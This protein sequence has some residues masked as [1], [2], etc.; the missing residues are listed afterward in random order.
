MKY[1]ADT[2]EIKDSRSKF[3]DPETLL[4]KRAI[5]SASNGVI[6]TDPNRTDNPIVFC[7]A[8]FERIT[9]YTAGE[10]LGRNCRFLQG[11][12]T[13]QSSLDKIRLSIQKKESCKEIIVNYRK[14]G[15][16]FWNE[17]SISPVY[18][19]NGRIRNFIGIQSDVTERILAEEAGKRSEEKFRS[20][21][22]NLDDGIIL[23]DESG[24]IIECNKKHE[25]IT[26]IGSRDV[27]GK[28]L[29]EIQ[30]LSVQ[31]DRDE[32]KKNIQQSLASGIVPPFEQ[33]YTVDF[34][35][36]AK[37]VSVQVTAIRS[38][39]G[40]MLCNIVKDITRR[41]KD[42]ERIRSLSRAVE[43]SPSGILLADMDGTIVYVNP[44][45]VS[46]GS[47]SDETELVNKSIFEFTDEKGK[48]A[49]INEILPAVLAGKKWNGELDV[50]KKN[51]QTIPIELSCA[52][53]NHE[54]DQPKYL[55]AVFTDISE[56][57]NSELALRE[58]E[59]KYRQVVDNIKE[60]IFQTDA[61][62]LWTFLNPA[63]EEITGFSL[64]ESLGK[65][66][67]DFVHPDDRERN[68]KL[69]L[70][71]IN[72]EKSYCRHTIR[73][74]TKNSGFRWIEVFARLTLDENDN[75][76]GTS[77]TLT[78]VTE[79]R[80]TEERMKE[81]LE[82]EIELNDLKSRFVSTISHEFRTPLTSILAS[83]EL[84]QRYNSKWTDEKKLETLGRIVKSVL[85]MNE[86]INDV[87]M[88][89]R[90]E[91][92]KLIFNPQEID[93]RRIAETV[94]QE[95]Q[96]TLTPMHKII[97][98]F[99]GDITAVLDEKLMHHILNNLLSNAVKYSPRGGNIY[100]SIRKELKELLIT[101]KD[102]GIGIPESDK[103]KLFQPFFRGRNIENI[104]G[105]GLG[106]SILQRAVHLHNGRIEF[107]S[108]PNKGT[109]FNVII[110]LEG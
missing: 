32:I 40:Y 91:T 85:N 29:W 95:I 47:Y 57:K 52:V 54:V 41:V 27:L 14:N 67:L 60:V 42:E 66:F 36:G 88:L 24:L 82:K 86:M 104:S 46:I 102:E 22:E 37:I 107:D 62:G 53:V 68:Q 3:P 101:I 2:D 17:L 33:K 56:R 21:V 108:T 63:W 25:E 16:K 84:L 65:N 69:F 96:P 6:I 55:L 106:L 71:L 80:K 5:D 45:I 92:G 79:R 43:N 98:E 26:G 50:F 8:A 77:G 99:G 93:A 83:A 90:A 75:I 51:G 58:S 19:E 74:L 103:E 76:I 34:P 72:R 97:P 38:G 13:S 11:P 73:Y 109:T 110:P 31:S 70:P 59:K 100:F 48:A 105:T 10:A 23:T 35:S 49:L 7:N 87:L 94:L 15:T 78:D 64:K 39:T 4:L 44:S 30:G 12:G 89:N 1:S 61:Q 18:D 9:G 20:V 81:S 28:Y